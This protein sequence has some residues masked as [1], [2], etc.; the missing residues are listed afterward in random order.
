[1]LFRRRKPLRFH[2]KLHH[3]MW[4]RRGWR[5]AVSYHG[6]R[7]MRLSGSPHSIAAGFAVGVAL[8]MT[9]FVGFHYLLCFAAAFLVRGNVLAAVLGTTIGNPLTFPVIWIATYET[10]SLILGWFGRE[11]TAMSFKEISHGLLNDSLH[12]IWPIFEPML[13]GSIPVA[14]IAAAIS[15]GAVYYAAAAFQS[16]RRHRVAV[17][18]HELHGS[19]S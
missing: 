16:A 4:P 2:Q 1:M 19:R 5:R 10:G 18:R 17:R 12:N 3:F 9:P 7:L 6:K 8:A 14:M 15:Y 11:H 13:I